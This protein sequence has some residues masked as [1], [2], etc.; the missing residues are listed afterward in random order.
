MRLWGRREA[1]A[2]LTSGLHQPAARSA[3][4]RPRG[5][6]GPAAC[7]PAPGE[8]PPATALKTG[9]AASSRPQASKEP[10]QRPRKPRLLQQACAPG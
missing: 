9:T 1:A 4:P 10:S 6:D 5:P 7:S 2:R 8:P 3:C